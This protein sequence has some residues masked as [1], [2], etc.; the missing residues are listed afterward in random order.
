[1]QKTQ[2][3]NL[4]AFLAVW[5]VIF[6][7]VVSF[8]FMLDASRTIWGF[9]DIPIIKY[10][11]LE[12]M[13][14]A[15]FLMIIS[16]KKNL[17]FLFYPPFQSLM[18]LFLFILSGSLITLLA[19]GADLQH[20]FL[21]RS[22]TMLAVIPGYWIGSNLLVRQRFSNLIVK[23]M[24]FGGLL[25]LVIKAANI[26]GLGFNQFSQM[27]HDE[28]MF[29]G[30]AAIYFVISSKVPFI[31][32]LVA[33]IFIASFLFAGKATEK[34]HIVFFFFAFGMYYNV[35]L[36]SMLS[37]L[38][39]R[40]RMALIGVFSLLFGA[41]VLVGLGI[42]D[43]IFEARIQENIYEP[44]FWTF[45]YRVEQ[46]KSSPLYGL[47][48]IGSPI[49]EI[50]WLKIPSHMDFLDILAFGGIVGILLFLI[51]HIY[52]LKQALKEKDF[53]WSGKQ[54][55]T[56]KY[57]VILWGTYLITAVANPIFDKPSIA[58]MVWFTV[59]YLLGIIFQQKNKKTKPYSL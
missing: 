46:F 59:G 25:L 32:W 5:I 37:S 21:G 26:F 6:S 9:G 47:L 4:Q 29:I 56:E 24:V 45:D 16:Y 13:V 20:S 41:L 51:P 15:S 35:Y 23:V 27:Y 43:Y 28:S 53:F 1:M 44:R 54:I 55:A 40:R 52:I 17:G 38:D 48:F 7:I 14:F 57:F 12:L 49:L 22:L 18:L 3:L 50:S 58:I 30:A 8:I 2:T 34:M 31:K 19:N 42:T 39:P 10:F 11:P 36:R 33:M